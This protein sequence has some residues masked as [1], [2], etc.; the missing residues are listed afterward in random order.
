[1][2]TVSYIQSGGISNYNGLQTSFQRRFTKGLAFDANYTWA[3]ALSDIT[4]FSQQ[5]S[6]QGWSDADPTRIREIEYGNSENDIQNRF[7]LGLNYELQFGKNFTGAKKVLLS[8]WQANTIVV[9][10]SG[11]PFTII[12]TGSGVDNPIESD[13][14]AHGFNNRATPQNS[15]GQDRP[16]QI[17]DARLGHK[18]LTH[19]FNTAAFAPQPLG[20]VGNAQRN[21][22]FGPNFRH[23]DLSL[24][25]TFPV[26][27]RLGIQFRA[28]SYNI[29]NTPNFYMPNGNSG[30]AFGNSAFGQISATDP[31]YTPRQYQFAL[32]ALF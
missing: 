20:T 27:E 15:G 19:F 14:I 32:K 22:L 21:S 9:W 26:T 16:N 5:G 10:Q 4:G 11:K 18:T 7:A 31:N 28:E 17:M 8:G 12:E 24:F 29:S 30:D 25:K 13:G 2:G 1:L 23:V 6:N 3:K